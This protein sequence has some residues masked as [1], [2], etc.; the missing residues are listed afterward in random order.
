[1]GTHMPMV[2]ACC[3]QETNHG[4]WTQKILN[5]STHHLQNLGVRTEIKKECWG[6][7]I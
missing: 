7:D 2:L 3:Q 1:V 6:G 5:R 4:A